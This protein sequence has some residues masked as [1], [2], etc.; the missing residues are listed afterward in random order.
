MRKTL[1]EPA[2]ATVA[3]DL[4]RALLGRRGVPL[5]VV[6]ALAPLLT[7]IVGHV[8][9]AQGEGHLISQYANI[10]RYFFLCG[11]LFFGTGWCFSNLFRGDILERSLHYFFLTPVRRDAITLGKYVTGVLATWLVLVPSAVL[12]FVFLFG[13]GNPSAVAYL[14]SGPGIT[15]MLQYAGITMLGCAAYGAVFLLLGLAARSP[16]VP[17]LL[18]FLFERVSVVLPTILK[19]LTVVHYLNSLLPVPASTGPF[20]LLA[21]P[22]PLAL[23]ILLPLALS[24]GVVFFAA[25]RVRMLEISYGVD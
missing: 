15:A 2:L 18:V 1:L 24:A 20:A 11:S 10:F 21:D 14:R 9:R 5:L 23:A 25:R 22:E 17:I 6:G 19:R 4:R 7:V 8:Q 12:S 13:Q 3:F 16:F